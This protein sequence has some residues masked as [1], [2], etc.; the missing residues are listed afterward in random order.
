MTNVPPKFEHFGNI[1]PPEDRKAV[2]AVWRQVSPD[3]PKVYFHFVE[4]NE[5]ALDDL[6]FCESED[7]KGYAKIVDFVRGSDG[8]ISDFVLKNAEIDFQTSMLLAKLTHNAI[9]KLMA[10][11]EAKSLCVIVCLKSR[12]QKDRK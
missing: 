7:Y 1:N 4:S 12:V 2:F 10:S 11:E 9:E 3:L 6:I 8:K 5:V